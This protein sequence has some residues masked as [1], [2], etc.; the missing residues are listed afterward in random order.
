MSLAVDV[1][2]QG[3]PESSAQSCSPG[4]CL[5]RI[6]DAFGVD[7]PWECVLTN[8]TW[9]EIA[10]VIAT[11]ALLN[12]LRAALLMAAVAYVLAG[13]ISLLFKLS[14]KHAAEKSIDFVTLL[15]FI[16]CTGRDCGENLLP[17]RGSYTRMAQGCDLIYPRSWL[18]LAHHK[19]I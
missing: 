19:K 18:P 16:Y 13:A 2:I 15:A 4:G 7:D 17:S 8:R 1:A 12:F 6:L 14:F 5:R 11:S 9:I 3:S 10:H